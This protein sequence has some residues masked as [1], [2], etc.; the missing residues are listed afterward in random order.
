MASSSNR[1]LVELLKRV[2][3]RDRSN[4]LLKMMYKRHDERTVED[5]VLDLRKDASN[6]FGWFFTDPVDYDECVRRVA[7]KIG[8]SKEELVDDEEK[9][10]LVA[11]KTCLKKYFESLDPAEREKKKQKILDEIGEKHK[12]VFNAIFLGSA[13]AFLAVMQIVGPAITRQVVL[14]CMAIY[15]SGQ[16]A[17][18]TTRMLTLAIPFLNVIMAGWLVFDLSGP[19]YR[20]IIPSV[21]NIALLRMEDTE[22]IENGS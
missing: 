1:K 3:E 7:I 19:A 18:N 2:E 6:T 10:E 4:D 22:A 20:K 17:L 9:N 5:L 16:I 12:E 13:T 8:V 21:L 14:R 15:A 11:L